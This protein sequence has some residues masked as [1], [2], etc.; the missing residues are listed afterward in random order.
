MITSLPVGLNFATTSTSPPARA[1]PFIRYF[2]SAVTLSLCLSRIFPVRIHR[3]TSKIDRESLSISSSPWIDIIYSRLRIFSRISFRIRSNIYILRFM[4][5][6]RTP[7]YHITLK[8]KRRAI[9]FRMKIFWSVLFPL[10]ASCLHRKNLTVP[11][12]VFQYL[13]VAVPIIPYYPLSIIPY[14]PLSYY[15]LS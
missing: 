15:P 1:F 7:H 4:S 11:L 8:A 12:T 6:L 10:R 14:Y 5:F 3:S 2:H 13:T 9:A